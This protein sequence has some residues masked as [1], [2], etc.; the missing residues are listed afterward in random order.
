MDIWDVRSLYRSES[1]ATV[2]R[3]V[4]RCRLYLEG[5]QVVRWDK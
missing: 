5:G 4:A 3:E 1:L 2:V